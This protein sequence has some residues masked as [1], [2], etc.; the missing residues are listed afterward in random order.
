MLVTEVR[1]G[2]EPASGKPGTWS[3]TEV[4]LDIGVAQVSHLK[5]CRSGSANTEQG[6]L[7]A[8]QAAILDNNHD[9]SVI[10]ISWGQAE[11]EGVARRCEIDRLFQLALTG[12]QSAAPQATTELELNGHPF[13]VAFPLRVARAA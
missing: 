6:W 7:H 13:T 12:V 1:P 4:Y 10:S 11:L 2:A 5:L 9:L 3:D 8:L